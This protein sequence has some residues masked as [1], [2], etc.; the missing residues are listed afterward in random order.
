M[1][2]K[3]NEMQICYKKPQPASIA[4]REVFDSHFQQEQTEAVN[5]LLLLCGHNNTEVCGD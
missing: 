5:M 1:I 2:D 3:L 4:V